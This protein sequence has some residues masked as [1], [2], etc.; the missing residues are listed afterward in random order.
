MRRLWPRPRRSR[1]P[2]LRRPPGNPRLRPREARSRQGDRGP[3]ALDPNAVVYKDIVAPIIEAKCAACHG[4]EKSKGKL[5][6]HTFADLMKG[7]S[8]GATTVVA[9]K[10]A[11]SLMITRTLLP[12]G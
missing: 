9:G 2:P 6:M 7:G 12:A 10:P 11:E 5:R 4:K 3:K 8:D 1:R